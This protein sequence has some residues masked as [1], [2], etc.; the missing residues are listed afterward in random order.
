[1]MW[2]PYWKMSVMYANDTKD[3]YTSNNLR[4]IL[5]MAEELSA[6]TEVEFFII[7]LENQNHEKHIQLDQTIK[8]EN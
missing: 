5:M 6:N 3:V 1:M 8:A 2:E 7:S 4:N